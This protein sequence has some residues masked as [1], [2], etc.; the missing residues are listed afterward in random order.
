MFCGVV[1][2]AKTKYEEEKIEIKIFKL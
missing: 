1:F 2:I